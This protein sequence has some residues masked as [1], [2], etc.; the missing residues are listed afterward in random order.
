VPSQAR[1]EFRVT[2][3]Q[4]PEL[5]E[6]VS[7]ESARSVGSYWDAMELV[8]PGAVGI[9][10]ENLLAQ[11]LKDRLPATSTRL[12]GELLAEGHA[13]P[14]VLVD[15]AEAATQD[16]EAGESAPW[17]LNERRPACERAALDSAQRVQAA[18]PE[19][20]VGHELLAR[21]RIAT[22]QS[23]AALDDMAR[24]ADKVSD[25]VHCL[26]RLA[27]L[28][29]W[30]NDSARLDAALLSVQN[31]GCAEDEECARNVVWVA[32]IEES[33][34]DLMRALAIYRRACERM[35]DRDTLRESAARVASK[36]G[37]HAE[38]ADDYTVLARRHPEIAQWGQAAEKERDL[39]IG[40]AP[41]SIRR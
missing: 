30:V 35:P 23:A 31:A 17:C 2:T 39:A 7:R 10:M 26:Q 5:V 38:A 36:A 28:A 22:G 24:E 41:K 6:L 19:K 33:R 4:A 18:L 16:L 13:E 34:G 21:A 11:Q 14:P 15:R 9:S 25:R 20:C 12:E 32:G 8:A 40:G 1:T 27:A 29:M 3:E 37:L